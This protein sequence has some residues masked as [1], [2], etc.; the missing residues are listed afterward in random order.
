MQCAK[1][2]EGLV[3]CGYYSSEYLRACEKFNNSWWQLQKSQSCWE[4]KM[5]DQRTITPIVADI[6]KFVTDQCCHVD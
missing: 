2:P 3:L 4:N 6:C 5:I 1:Q